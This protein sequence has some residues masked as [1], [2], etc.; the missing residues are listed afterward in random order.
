MAAWVK[1]CVSTIKGEFPDFEVVS[2]FSVFDLSLRPTFGGG[3]FM[4]TG[5]RRL[6][7]TF[8]IDHAFEA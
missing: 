1:L 5:L 4:D 3:G 8:A 6:A 2:A 7:Q